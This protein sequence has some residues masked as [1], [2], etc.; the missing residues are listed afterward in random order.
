[1]ERRLAAIMVADIVGYS[2]L[3]EKAEEQTADRVA[4]CQELIREKA[5]ALGGRIFN[6]AGDAW[7]AEF[8]SPIN[9]L[10]CAAEIRNALAG[11]QDME[12]DPLRL[13]F[14]LHLADV[15][16][17]GNDLVGDGVNVAARLQ[18]AA[19]P[20]S[21]D[22]SGA[23][24]DNIRRNSPFAFEDLGERH[25]KS[26]SLPIRIY[27]LREEM[28]RHRLQS[29][30]TRVPVAGEKRPLS[31]AVLPFRVM[32]GDED[33]R[34]LAEGLTDELIVELARFRRLFVS[35]RSAS[36]ALGDADPVKVGTALGVRYVL[37]GQVGRIGDQVRIALTLIETE[38]GSVVWSD[39]ISWPFTELLH[40]LDAT[41]ARI[42]ATVFGRVEDAG[43]ITARR[44]PP[45]NMS[46]F[47]CL[48]R[49]IE[50][51]RLGGVLEEHSR[52]AVKWFTR[53][54]ELDP[55]YA[56]AYAWRVCAAS[57]LPEF[58]FPESG[59]PDI[60]RALELDPCDAEANRIASFYELLKGDFDQAAGLMRRAMELNP[61]DAY[62]KARSAAVLTFIGEPE[63]ALRLLDKAEALDPLLP[64]WCVEE[65]GV[66]LYSLGRHEE[67]LAALGKLVF[68]TFRSRLYRAAALM[69]LGRPEEAGKLVKEAL[70][71]KPRFTVSRFL[72]QERYRD[73]SLRRQLR[74]RLQD[75]GL[76][77]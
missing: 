48:L 44:K 74:G 40:L 57:D 45:E 70:A 15:V 42:A 16:V 29:A 66:A 76:P 51:H 3:M 69:A 28:A 35:S 54:I 9:A 7:L 2:A 27:R 39:K 43:M 72:F 77:P 26:L 59:E 36:F 31:L 63:E 25:L 5:A 50:H 33:Q 47:E 12:G 75:A 13:R 56:A 46:A 58:S 73:P 30:P 23:F 55:S 52:E 4:R 17:R 32:G 60:R 67:A 19:E 71:S 22:V 8:G 61:S 38:K 14:G 20:D 37:E 10:R 64:V 65:R 18:Q 62:I 6:T 11:S 24:F 41:A 53:A 34:F 68:Q 1:M 49:G 21:I